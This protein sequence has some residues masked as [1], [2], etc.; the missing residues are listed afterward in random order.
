MEDRVQD[1]C[2]DPARARADL[3]WLYRCLFGFPDGLEERGHIATIVAV[4]V[5]F[6]NQ[7]GWAMLSQFSTRHSAGGEYG[8]RSSSPGYPHWSYRSNPG[9]VGVGPEYG[10]KTGTPWHLLRQVQ[11]H[12]SARPGIDLQ[13]NV[14]TRTNGWETDP[15]HH[16][17]TTD[18]LCIVV[19]RY[20]TVVDNTWRQKLRQKWPARYRLGI[21]YRY[22][23]S[24]FFKVLPYFGRRR[25]TA[26]VFR[27][28][29]VCQATRL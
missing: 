25:K 14:R 21:P 19:Q 29:E 12:H 4:H 23:A 27:V 17:G 1:T 8:C 16:A 13:R 10:S 5:W 3:L 18:L 22:E 6:A 15:H 20:R 11:A 9:G 28:K 24:T 2:L 7:C 26:N